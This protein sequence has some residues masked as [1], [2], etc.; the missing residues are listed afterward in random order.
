MTL[1]SIIGIGGHTL[2]LSAIALRLAYI[3]K[4]R[5]SYSYFLA[6]VALI[7]VSVPIGA[8]P[9]VQ[10]T[11]GIFGDLSITTI[12]L[13]GYFFI[14]PTTP[15]NSSR[16]LIYLIITTGLLF[17]PAALGL[18]MIDPYQWGYLNSYRGI[19]SP[20]LFLAAL[21]A[22]A[23]IAVRLKNELMLWCIVLA[24]GAFLLGA[25]QSKNIWDYLIDPLIVIFGLFRIGIEFIKQLF[26]KKRAYRDIHR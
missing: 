26:V 8:M 21:A 2:L 19:V 17:Y 20:M 4:L 3:C 1:S 7:A 24:T 12:V 5:S 11:R 22:V 23:S 10:V 14:F 6:I 15:R 25:M 16:Q 13:L 18:G 9:V